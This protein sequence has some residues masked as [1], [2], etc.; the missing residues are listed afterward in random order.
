MEELKHEISKPLVVKEKD[1]K[2]SG[3]QIKDAIS[4]VL[5]NKE[6]VGALRKLSKE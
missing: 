2:L 3:K 6:L 1:N 5:K 4:E